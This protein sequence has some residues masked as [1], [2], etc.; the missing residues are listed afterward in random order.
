LDFI[1]VILKIGPSTYY[2]ATKDQRAFMT[3]KETAIKSKK[4]HIA[5]LEQLLSQK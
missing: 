4:E 2:Q 1:E 5:Q 3:A